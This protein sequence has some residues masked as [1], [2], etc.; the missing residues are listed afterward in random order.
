M[1]PQI[2]SSVALREVRARGRPRRFAAGVFGIAGQS[3]PKTT[4]SAMRPSRGRSSQHERGRQ[5]GQVEVDVRLVLGEEL[6]LLDHQPRPA[7]AS[8]NGSSGN[9]RRDVLDVVGVAVALR[10][11][12]GRRTSRRGSGPA[13]GAPRRARRCATGAGRRG[14][15]SRSSASASAA[16]C[17]ARRRGAGTRRAAA[18]RRSGC[19]ST[20]GSARRRRRRTRPRTRC[21]GCRSSP[22]ACSASTTTRSTPASRKTSANSVGVGCAIAEAREVVGVDAT[23]EVAHVR[24]VVVPAQEVGVEVDDHGWPRLRER[25]ELARDG[26]GRRRSR[27]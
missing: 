17:R 10:A 23:D 7:W 9:S 26:A 6:A 8:T 12:R 24:D 21:A 19:S 15:R 25:V 4:L 16:A 20:P 1:P 27:P 2:A 11:C 22:G 5:A 14:G 13:R 3:V 18:S